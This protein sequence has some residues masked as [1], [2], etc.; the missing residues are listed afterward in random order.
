MKGYKMT[1]WVLVPVPTEVHEVVMNLVS[2]NQKDRGERTWPAPGEISSGNVIGD[3]VWQGA[4][5]E[6]EPWPTSA[7]AQLADGRSLPAQ[8][9]TIAMDFCAKHPSERFGTSE[10]VENTDLT[11]NEWRDACRKLTAHL[12]ANYEGLP[13]WT[14]EP[15]LGEDIWPLATASGRNLHEDLQVYFGMAEEQ[16]KCWRDVRGQI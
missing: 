11:L 7:L 1:E 15:Y 4:L 10:I 12:R 5:E 14:R 2:K 6:T 3:I 16:A 8:R 9:W 13:K